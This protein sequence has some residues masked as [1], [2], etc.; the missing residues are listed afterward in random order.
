MG[1]RR[2]A[3]DFRARS[4]QH[5]GRT[6]LAREAV[7]I[8]DLAADPEYALPEVI[9]VGKM[10]TGLGV[11]LLREGEPIGVIYLARQR[12]EPFTKRRCRVLFRTWPTAASPE[13]RIW[14][15]SPERRDRSLRGT[16]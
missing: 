5:R 9:T 2:A 4:R 6:L 7:Q 14:Q 16:I 12:V 15:R 10:R 1:C 8:A 11:P 3:S 13:D